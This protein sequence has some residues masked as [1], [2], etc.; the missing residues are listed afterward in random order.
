MAQVLEEHE[1]RVRERQMK[2]DA[3]SLELAA[4]RTAMQQVQIAMQDSNAAA[5]LAG[6]QGMRHTNVQRST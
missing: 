6:M 5:V 2:K 4:G 3:A 1:G